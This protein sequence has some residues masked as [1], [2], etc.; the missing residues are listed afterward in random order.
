MY[1]FMSRN[2]ATKYLE[3]GL[4]YS[5]DLWGVFANK[6]Y[7][8]GITFAPLSAPKLQF[9]GADPTKIEKRSRQPGGMRYSDDSRA[10]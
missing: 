6:W 2:D 8:D 4:R 5:D 10:K 1:V 3:N 7:N 9:W